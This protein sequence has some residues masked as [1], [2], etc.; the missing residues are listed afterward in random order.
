VALAL[1][2][3]ASW[4]KTAI[5]VVTIITSS[6]V[7]FAETAPNS[8]QQDMVEFSDSLVAMD[9]DGNGESDATISRDPIV[10]DFDPFLQQTQGK[11]SKINSEP[12][13]LTNY[14]ISES[15]DTDGDG[16]ADDED[17]Y[18][19][20][21]TRP[22]Y[23]G[24]MSSDTAQASF[25]TDGSAQAESQFQFT[26]WN[27]SSFNL[28]L[29]EFIV[30]DGFDDVLASTS[31]PSLLGDD[32]VLSV[33]E[34]Q[35]LTLTLNNARAGPISLVY[36]YINPEDETNETITASFDASTVNVFGSYALDTDGD[37]EDNN[38]DDD[39]DGD[40]VSDTSD[41]YPLISLNGL[42]DTDGDGIPNDCDAACLSSGMT[43]DTDDDNDTV[44]DVDDAFPLDASETVDTDGDGVGDNSDWA[45]EDS[46]E[47]ADTDGDG[48]GNNVDADDD[49]DGVADSEDGFPL[50]DLGDLTDTD[51]DGRPNE[52][53]TACVDLGM[54]ADSDDDN[55][56]V[57]DSEDGFPLIDLGGLTDTDSD[58]RPNECNTACVDLGMSADLDDDNDGVP[59]SYDPFPLDASESLDADADSIGN[60]ADNCILISN[61]D[62]V[63][64]DSDGLG[65]KC[66]DDDD[67][68]GV[69]DRLD[70][71]P[72]DG[73]ETVD[74]DEDGLGN[75]TDS[76][77]DNDDVPDVNDA[78]PL[79][80]SESIDTDEDGVGNNRDVDDDGDRILDS[81]DA[82][83]LD[84]SE[85]VDTDN[86]GVGNNADPDDD[87]DGVSDGADAFPLDPTES[88]D[89][90]GDGIG[91]NSDSDDDGDGISDQQDAFP[92]LNTESTDSNNN[93]IGDNDEDRAALVASDILTQKMISYAGSVAASFI[94][95]IEDDYAGE[96]D[97]WTIARGESV[98]LSIRCDNG[99]GYDATVTRS[100]WTV[101]TI[102]M[103][104]ENCIDQNFMTTNGSATVTYDDDL[105]DQ[106]TPREEHPFVFSF[107][108]LR[109]HDTVDK[110][111]SY[112]GSLYCD[113]HYNSIA[114]S[115]T[116]RY[117][118]ETEIY[119]GRWGSVFDD[120]GSVY[121]GDN[122]LEVDESGNTNVYVARYLP[123]CDFKNITVMEG[124][125]NHT[126]LDVQYVTESNGSG[127]NISGYTRSEKLEKVRNKEVFLR[128]VYTEELGWVLEIYSR[129]DGNAGVRLSGQG[130]YSINVYASTIP[131][132]YWALRENVGDIIFQEVDQYSEFEWV[133]LDETTDRI[134]ANSNRYNWNSMWDIDND[135]FTEV[136]TSPWVISRFYSNSQ[137]NRILRFEDWTVV[138]QG[139]RSG[140]I[141]GYNTGFELYDGEIW[142]QDEN[143]D[144]INE[145]FS[146]DDDQDGVQD[147]VDVFPSDPSETTDTDGDGIGDN[148]DAFPGDA[149]ETLD[150]DGDGIGDNV[151]IFPFDELE[152]ID[153]DGDGIGNNSDNDDDNDG[154]SDSIDEFPYDSSE[155]VDSDNDGVGNNSDPDD[156]NDGYADDV[157][158][159]PFDPLEATD[160]D[161][162]GLGNN[163]DLDDD[164]DLVSDELEILNGTNPLLGDSDYDGVSDFFD[165]FPLDPYEQIDADEDG[166]GNNT[167]LDDDN[168][169]VADDADA[170]PLDPSE[171]TDSDL[172]GVGDNSDAF[173]NDSTESLD[174]DS[175]GI[176]D[177]ADAF[178]NDASETVDSD[179][180]GTGDNSD[181]FP[182][183]SLYNADSD[184][185]GMPDAWETRY[186]LDPNDASDATSDQDNDGVTALD[187]FLAGTIPSGSID[188]DGNGEYD[189]LTDGLLLL[190]GMFGLDGSALVTGTIAS[191]AAY[192]E[193]ADI[194]SRIAILGDLADIDGNGEIDALTDGLLTLRYLFGLE[195]DTLINGVVASDATRTSAEQIE[196]HLKTLMPAL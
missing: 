42:A 25:W 72:L 168:D 114:Q 81:D 154:V 103:S 123:N 46:S 38:I 149:S 2:A 143:L 179:S 39:D 121:W 105:W 87:N 33:G 55:D 188:L 122:Y 146:L 49:N 4:S 178:P 186:G 75:N 184:N 17:P 85:S 29:F 144:G 111:F 88:I 11:V 9:I 128:D 8:L 96:S 77:D 78:F 108:N 156:D 101:L 166:L 185:D 59:D 163:A 91:N 28:T 98:N 142:Y 117:E 148:S 36:Y 145:L 52:C 124:A 165:I 141:S 74:S 22:F 183:D 193:S 150:S 62:Q 44:L 12:T 120:L 176:G 18:P 60:N 191:D 115:W 97:D 41:G 172:D 80:P 100:D 170:F 68:D 175:D 56:G 35:G 109:I 161:G 24:L 32:G 10:R 187:E 190:R 127:Y 139:P 31:D 99:G 129:F 19:L 195:G 82:F 63:D 155:S 160:T 119:E 106:P 189:A 27:N 194:E 71:F 65:N 102:S 171:S 67:G 1:R 48:I 153:S 118:G 37:G 116:Y 70:S 64:T 95:D 53:D 167:D 45:P 140:P 58:G 137:W 147:S 94:D 83:P 177:N 21:G 169:G 126:I 61:A 157:D 79:D 30:F 51:S 181:A 93:E 125:K 152:S 131:T 76:D 16:L 89:T 15:L 113:S 138:A 164:G 133:Y 54:S 20:D 90:D 92:L 134:S 14:N 47:S 112:T 66:D 136:I 192:T 180:D 173:P 23:G 151:D 57:A 84:G 159:F 50:I 196:A 158:Q 107:T 6:S 174:T 5:C 40:S 182:N 135:G 104:I 7:S 130:E 110:T 132:Y 13:T 73:S 86:D 162:D 69:S 43:A 34:G 26:I 3:G